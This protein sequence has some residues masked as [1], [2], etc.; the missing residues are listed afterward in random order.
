MTAYT[1]RTGTRSTLDA[2]RVAGW[3]L[4]VTPEV[5]R[6]EGFSYGLDNGAWTVRARPAAWDPESFL[7]MVDRLGAGSDWLVVPDVVGDWPATREKIDTWLPRL[8]GAAP[9]LLL[10]V[11]DGATADELRPMLSPTVGIFV[12]GSNDAPTWWKVSTL[13][14]WGRLARETG[15]YL[16]V[17]RVNSAKRIRWAAD[18]GADSFDGKSP[19]LFPC[20]LPSLDRAVRHRPRQVPLWSPLDL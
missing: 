5:P 19:V 1:S 15:C 16:H 9:R 20:T 10:A 12:G 11:Q 18:C 4:L 8:Q 17:G 14:I 3:R 2:L 6:T 13:P 7:R